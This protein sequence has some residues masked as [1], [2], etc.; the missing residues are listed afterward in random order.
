A[1][2]DTPPPELVPLSWWVVPIAVALTVGPA[3]GIG[4]LRGANRSARV[5]DQR[6][7]RVGRQR[8]ELGDELARQRERERIAREVHDVLG[9][10]LSLLNLHAGALE[11]NAREDAQLAQSAA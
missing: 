10:R 5:A 9:H 4:L 1:P 7:E 3:V 11:V 2:P 8:A 6:A